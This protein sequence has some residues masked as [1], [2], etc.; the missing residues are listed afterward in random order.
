MFGK[1][2]N[3]YELGVEGKNKPR[4]SGG[5]GWVEKKIE[6]KN[7]KKNMHLIIIYVRIVY[8]LSTSFDSLNR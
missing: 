3:M 5:G 6:G 7:V 4:N 2:S 1:L 8:L